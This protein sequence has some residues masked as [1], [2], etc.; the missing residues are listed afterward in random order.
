MPKRSV[1]SDIKE[2]KPVEEINAAMISH[3][4]AIAEEIGATAVMVYV[5]VIRSRKNLQELIKESRCILAARSQDVIDELMFMETAEDRIVPVPYMDL[6]RLSQIKV[7]A[8]LAL[9]KGLIKKGDRLVCLAGSP[10]YGILDN[11]R[12]LDVDREFEVFSS[13]NLQVASQMHLP[14][15]FDRLLTIALEL[16][17]EG[18]EGKPLG[19]IFV[20]GD[21]EKVMELSS[22][23]IINP[24]SAVP[25][26]ERNILDTAVKE[27]IREFATIDG[28][29][30]IRW[31][32]S[33]RKPSPESVSRGG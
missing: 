3:A 24:F 17:E 11:L 33:C 6:S 12:V 27:T 31:C 16:G 29:F 25:E 10:T 19:T 5:D 13:G 30:V 22:Q 4:R 2:Q 20:F 32:H 15:I 1:R 18:K 23:M 21:H 7:A 9:S 14:H 8:I 28:A 26:N